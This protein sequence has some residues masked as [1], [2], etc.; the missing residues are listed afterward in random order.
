[1]TIHGPAD[2]EELKDTVKFKV[3]QDTR[4]QLNK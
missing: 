3:L 1:M 2:L 4:I